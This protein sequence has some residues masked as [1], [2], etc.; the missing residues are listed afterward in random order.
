MWKYV[1]IHYKC[2]YLYVLD[3]SVAGG[4]M[5]TGTVRLTY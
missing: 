1:I 3:N 5:N 2:K 4:E